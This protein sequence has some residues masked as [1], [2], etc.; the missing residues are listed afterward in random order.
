MLRLL[1]ADAVGMSTV[2]EIMVAHAI[3]LRCL[4]VSVITDL[5]LP[6]TL[7]KANIQHIIAAAHKAEPQLTRLF[8][9]LI[10]RI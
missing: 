9:E 8:K 10:R 2:P 3:G 6:D 1:Q 7:Q 4:G 5:G